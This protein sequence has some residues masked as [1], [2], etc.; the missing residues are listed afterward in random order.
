[1]VAD[2]HNTSLVAEHFERLLQS[3][4]EHI[5]FT[6]DFNA[7]ALKNP[8]DAFYLVFAVYDRFHGIAQLKGGFNGTPINNLARSEEHTS[9][10]QSRG[11]LVCRLLLEKKNTA[12]Y[13]PIQSA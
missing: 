3:F 8:R 5:Q 2:C 7:D 12:T 6:I 10:L 1:M 13:Q 11:H 9:E 4:A